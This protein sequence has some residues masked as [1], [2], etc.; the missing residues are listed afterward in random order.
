MRIKVS[1][2]ATIRNDYFF[3]LQPVNIIIL[4]VIYNFVSFGFV[5]Y[6]HLF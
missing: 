1:G 5:L 6:P 2:E 4:N 3:L